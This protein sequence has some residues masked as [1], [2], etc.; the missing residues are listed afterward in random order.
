MVRI[1]Y[2]FKWI[3]VANCG[4]SKIVLRQLFNRNLESK[5]KKLVLLGLVALAFIIAIPASAQQTLSSKTAQVLTASESAQVWDRIGSHI[6]HEPVMSRGKRAAYSVFPGFTQANATIEVTTSGQN[7]RASFTTLTSVPENSFILFRMTLANG[8][9]VQL[10]GFSVFSEG[11]W[12]SELW[13][14]PFP[15]IWPAGPTRFEVIIISSNSGEL[16]YVSALALVH[17]CCLLTGPLTS[18]DVSADG[19]A[20]NIA[21]FFQGFIT[22]TINGRPVPMSSMGF[23]PTTGEA[24]NRIDISQAG[25]VQGTLAV[26]SGGECSSREIYVRGANVPK[27]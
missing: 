10:E 9:M 26:C 21:G 23:S 1:C 25:I 20:V 11:T 15:N 7:V 12:G 19:T 22:A 18:A 2:S 27:G 16:T 24:L 4:H 3:R 6:N 8:T 13:N 5:V 17:T 14:G